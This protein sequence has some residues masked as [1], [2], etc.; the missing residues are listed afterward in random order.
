MISAPERAWHHPDDA[1]SWGL[2]AHLAAIRSGRSRSVG[3]LTDLEG[4]ARWMS[5]HGGKV[6]AV[7]PLL[8]TF[9]RPPSEPSP[10]APVSRLFWSELILDLG[11]AHEP[12]TTPARIDVERAEE[13][14]RRALAGRPEPDASA[15]DG[16]LRR[17]ARFRGAQARL[18]RDWRS[19]PS[20]ARSGSL[21]ED[22][23]DREEE[24]FHGKA[25]VE[26]GRQLEG[27]RDRLGSEG[28]RIGL[29]L[30]VGVHPDGF[31]TWSRPGLFASGMSVGA[32]PDRAFP[33]GQDWGF[34][35][36]DPRASREEGHAYTA[37]AVA[38]HARI[39]G[40]L[41]IDHVMSLRR[42]FWIPH[43]GDVG[44]GTYVRYPMEEL[45]AVHILESHRHRCALVGENLGVVPEE[46]DEALRRHAI[47]GMSLAQFEAEASEPA[48]PDDDE[49]AMVGNHDTA[50]LVG[51][52]EGRDI[53]ERVR[54]DLLDPDAA[55]DER[56]ARRSTVQRL[57]E[58]V[59]GDAVEAHELLEGLLRWLG[60][61]PSPLVLPWVED[62]W[63]EPDPVNVP[64]TRSSDRPNWQRVWR[65]SLDDVMDDPRINALL[66]E[67]DAARAKAD[68]ARE[69]GEGGDDGG[70]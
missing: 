35:P 66:E 68:D 10:Y 63:L 60:A 22:H 4:F 6:V 9:N 40:L 32:P 27:L 30:A 56:R 57:M 43:G 39:A 47:R 18:G 62:L 49:V 5:V 11:D 29:D 58:A 24:R 41:R 38:H 52:L 31:D 28:V 34:L 21:G 44:H 7:L 20:D 42:L 70:G 25:Q 50:T 59:C 26:A 53:D 37:A 45:L 54:H 17:Y 23:V 36:V 19:W 65:R 64:G 14:V 67:L 1:P 13:E 2:S 33:S 61:S 46:I 69:D 51:W 55:D 48:P 8:P 12:T 3:D 16:R 15:V